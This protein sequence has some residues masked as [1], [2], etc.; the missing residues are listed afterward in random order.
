MDADKGLNSGT[1][2]R[3]TLAHLYSLQSV[4]FFISEKTMLLEYEAKKVNWKKLFQELESE[5]RF[6]LFTLHKTVRYVMPSIIFQ[7]R[8]CKCCTYCEYANEIYPSG[9]SV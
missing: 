7:C 4:H 2:Y 3:Y 9:Y 6:F 5:V 8:K 1:K